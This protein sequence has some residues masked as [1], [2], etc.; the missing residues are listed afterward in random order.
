M[1]PVTFRV[2]ITV[3]CLGAL[4]GPTLADD[5]ET[6]ATETNVAPAAA[7]SLTN[8]AE[9]IP[10]SAEATNAVPAAD[11]GRDT[12]RLSEPTL[13]GL[14]LR[15]G[16]RLQLAAQEPDVVNPVALAFDATGRLYV[17]ERGSQP[18]FGRIKILADEDGDGVY[19][20]AGVFADQ[21]NSP[22]AIACYGDGL[23]VA[24]DKEIWFFSDSKNEGKADVRRK[25]YEGFSRADESGREGITQLIWGPD[26]RIHAACNGVGGEVVCAALMTVQPLSVSGYDLAFNPRTLEMQLE[27]GG[28]SCGLGF[29]SAARR[30]TCSAQDPIQFTVV[31]PALARQ[32]PL[33]QWPRNTAALTAPNWR[34]YPLHVAPS[35]TMADLAVVAA[36]FATNRFARPTSLLVYRGGALSKTL[37]ESLFITDAE[38]RLVTCQQIRGNGVVPLIARYTTDRTSEFLATRDPTFRPMQI[39]AAPDGTLCIAD[40]ARPNPQ[41][42]EPR[43]RIWR[44][45]P[46]HAVA[47]KALD[48]KSLRSADL[49]EL[50]D[51]SNGWARDTA[52]RLLFERA[53]NATLAAAEKELRW[54][55]DAGTKV[56]LLHL[57]AANNALRDTT[58]IRALQ[59]KDA[60]VRENAAKLC[61][62]FLQRGMLPPDLLAQLAVNA[63]DVSPGVRYHLA[64]VLGGVRH[65][66]VPG[67][68]ADALLMSPA[69][70]MVQS[71]VLAAANSCAGDLLLNLVGSPYIRQ[72]PAGWQFLRQIGGM[73][74]IQGSLNLDAFL[75]QL[76]N[77]GLTGVDQLTLACDVGDGLSAGGRTFIGGTGTNQWHEFA[78]RMVRVAIGN[79]PPNLR[80]SAIRFVGYS[81]LTMQE[82]GDW[83]MALLVPGESVDVQVAAVDALSRF[84]D[85]IVTT[86][87]V[88]RW[89]RLSAAAQQEILNKLLEQFDRTQALIGALEIGL[90]PPGALNDVQINFLRAHRDPTTAARAQRLFGPMPRPEGKADYSAILKARGSAAVGA[91]IYQQRCAGCHPFKDA[92]RPFG[93][94]LDTLGK[95]SD[96][97]WLTDI[98]EPSREIDPQYQTK[99]L[100]RS[101]NQLLY[102]LVD[103]SDRDFVSIQEPDGRRTVLPRSQVEDTFPQDWSLMPVNAGLGLSLNELAS[104]VAFL[105]SAD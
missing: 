85:P 79:G 62:L 103:D 25:V 31:D 91:R 68:L 59:D 99:V 86:T 100:Q 72:F 8:E 76:E 36:R 43:G 92:G 101:N 105:H 30:F 5:S 21:V 17:A 89:P 77:S 70:P 52:A 26:N 54:S 7:G 67:M 55:W 104:L 61:P 74:G 10:V 73:A 3:I 16:F 32:N 75:Y 53:D 27:A 14:Q 46:T 13:H 39:V 78:N 95:R 1:T 34:L 4:C 38:L 80:A 57:L 58:L 35:T 48:L 56:Q 18:E 71:A 19:E 47:S 93:P 42:Y 6:P 49:I 37:E 22:T 20:K 12:N 40:L 69:D 81:G 66:A 33:Y 23:F 2:L 50:L 45:L 24:A 29:D 11:S 44:I 41:V 90:L 102:G 28:D 96:E 94:R 83:M 9:N 84:P 60:T 97:Q 65:P 63:K 51:A 15:T 98:L 87:F 88:Q 82:A 64:L